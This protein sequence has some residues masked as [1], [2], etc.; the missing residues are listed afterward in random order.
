MHMTMSMT[1]HMV[2]HMT[3]TMHMH[4]TMYTHTW[5]CACTFL[6]LAEERD[7]LRVL[8]AALGLASNPSPGDEPPPSTAWPR[9]PRRRGGAVDIG[10]FSKN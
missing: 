6:Q 5:P 8:R 9:E 2:M 7:R 3:M 1:M 10:V 4:M